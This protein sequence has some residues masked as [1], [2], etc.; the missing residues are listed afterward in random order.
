MKNDPAEPTPSGTLYTAGNGAT[1]RLGLNNE[2]SRSSPTQ[3]PGTQW[4]GLSFNGQYG[5]ATKTDGSLWVWGYGTYGELGQNT[6]VYYSSP[7]QLPGTQWSTSSYEKVSF[8]W[9]AAC[10]FYIKTDG[11]L[12]GSG[13]NSGSSGLLGLNDVVARSSPTQIPG[14]QW[15]KMGHSREGLTVTKTDGTL[16]FIGRNAD[17]YSVGISGQNDSAQH[18]S[19]VQIPGTQWNQSTGGFGNMFATKTDGTLWAWGMNSA[20]G[21]YLGM[22]GLN[23]HVQRSSPTQLPGTQWSKVMSATYATM[24]VKTDG[25]LWVWGKPNSGE[26]GLN[27]SGGVARSSPVQLPGTQWTTNLISGRHALGATKTD[28]TLWV[29]GKNNNGELM[30]GINDKVPRS[31]PTQVPGTEWNTRLYNMGDNAGG[32][33]II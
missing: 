8:V 26:T 16:W 19:P 3:I 14:T 31:S 7:V 12:W 27:L 2:I 4:T 15:D 21:A 13:I 24:A 17:S 29:W 6:T 11:T 25:T 32:Y 10:A 5:S 23:D 22:L 9:N 30:I 18:S 28:G 33:I 1:G 20:L